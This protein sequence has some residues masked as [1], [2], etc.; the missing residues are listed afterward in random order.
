[1]SLLT[2]DEQ[3]WENRYR[4]GTAAWDLGAP[5]PPLMAYMDQYVHVSADMLIPG[6]GNAYEALELYERGFRNITVLDF[7][8][9]AL[10]SLRQHCLQNGVAGM[11]L[12]QEDFFCHT[13]QY[14]LILEQTFFCA[15]DPSRRPDYAAQMASLLRP[16]GRLVGV[17]FNRTFDQGPPFGGSASDYAALFEPAFHI[18]T[19]EP[20]YNSVAPR[21]GSEVFLILEK[22]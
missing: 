12:V 20:C 1:M 7:A 4:S 18:R 22:K 5:S 11:R 3:Y 13:G 9:T 15:I 2:L 19:L 16:G 17:W 6:C 14:D 8:A 10:Q 21:S